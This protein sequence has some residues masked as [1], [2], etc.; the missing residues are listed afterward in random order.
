MWALGTLRMTLSADF[1][2]SIF[3][4]AQPHFIIFPWMSVFSPKVNPSFSWCEWV[5]VPYHP[6]S[7]DDH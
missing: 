4:K 7:L 3:L 2:A 1:P 5:P 6:N